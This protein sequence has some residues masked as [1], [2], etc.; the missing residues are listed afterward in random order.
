[1]RS[2]VYVCV[3]VQSGYRAAGVGAECAVGLSPAPAFFLSLSLN[4]GAPQMSRPL[5]REHALPFW[6]ISTPCRSASPDWMADSE[7]ARRK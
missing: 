6:T 5:P 1:M 4:H 3:C 7:R 2:C